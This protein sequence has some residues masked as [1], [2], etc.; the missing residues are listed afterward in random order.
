MP[1]LRSS[2]RGILLKNRENLSASSLKTYISTLSQLYKNLSQDFSERAYDPVNPTRYSIQ[3]NTY[4]FPYVDAAA[5]TAAGFSAPSNF[6]TGDSGAYPSSSS[7]YFNP[8]IT[9]SAGFSEIVGYSPTFSTDLNINGGYSVPSDPISKN[10]EKSSTFCEKSFMHRHFPATSWLPTAPSCTPN[11]PP[12]TPGAPW[13]DSDRRR[14][15]SALFGF[16]SFRFPPA[17]C[18]SY[19]MRLQGR[20]H[21]RLL[22]LQPAK[23]R[24]GE[25]FLALG[26]RAELRTYGALNHY[27]KSEDI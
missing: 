5:I 12:C 23:H 22:G 15:D 11:N 4:Q 8:K 2:L 24:L 9:M 25:D 6:N 7:Y 21:A 1:V 26:R 18:R 13:V 20:A 19:I 16:P 27:R 3:I 14:W 17:L 10:L